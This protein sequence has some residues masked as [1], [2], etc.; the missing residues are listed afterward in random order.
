MARLAAGGHAAPGLLHFGVRLDGE[1]I[2]PLI[3]L[4]GVPRAILLPCC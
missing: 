1:Y 2:N 4:G 3:L